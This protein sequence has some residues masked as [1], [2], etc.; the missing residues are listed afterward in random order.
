[1]GN[2]DISESIHLFETTEIDEDDLTEEQIEAITVYYEQ[3][4]IKLNNDTLLRVEHI[5][6]MIMDIP[7]KEISFTILGNMKE[8]NEELIAFEETEW[9]KRA[10]FLVQ[11]AHD[12]IV[13]YHEIVV[14]WSLLEVIEYIKNEY[15]ETAH[16]EVLEFSINELLEGRIY[17]A[18]NR[19]GSVKTKYQIRLIHNRNLPSLFRLFDGITL[20]EGSSLREL[21]FDAD[22]KK[23]IEYIID[24]YNECQDNVW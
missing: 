5:R 12:H 4:A 11:S 14:L 7:I 6:T 17:E 20:E 2:M 13:C 16:T 24:C 22:S 1:M 18:D 21:F 10:Y 19:M 9:K 8:L 15:S 3:E 23:D